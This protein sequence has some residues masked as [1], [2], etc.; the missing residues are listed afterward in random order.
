VTYIPAEEIKELNEPG[1]Y[2]AVMTQPGRRSVS[3][4]K[5]EQASAFAMRGRW[6]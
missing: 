1:I 5:P 2:I 6:E 3:L 4:G